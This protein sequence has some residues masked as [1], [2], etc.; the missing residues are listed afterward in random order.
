[1][2]LTISSTGSHSSQDSDSDVLVNHQSPYQW[3]F[4]RLGLS[5]KPEPSWRLLV[6]ST[7]DSPGAGPGHAHPVADPDRLYYRRQAQGSTSGINT[8]AQR[9]LLS[10]S[11]AFYPFSPHLRLSHSVMAKI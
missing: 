11:Q 2:V 7:R 4:F 9:W 3:P 6:S 5:P 8:E 10:I 1:M